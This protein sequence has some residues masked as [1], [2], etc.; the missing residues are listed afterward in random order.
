MNKSTETLETKVNPANEVETSVFPKGFQPMSSITQK[1]EV[2][3]R[4]GYHRRWFRS[5]PG[6]I[7]KAQRAGF[8]FV[9]YDE[10]SLVN[11]DLGGDAKNSGNTDLGTR[12]SIISGDGADA[13]TRVS[14]I[15]G[16][17]ADATGQV[18]RLYLM[19]C[20]MEFYEVSRKLVED[21]NESVAEMLRGGQAGAG[22]AG[23]SYNDVTKRYSRITM[24]DLFTPKN[25]R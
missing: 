10:A 16:D 14:I 8:R 3:E 22:G 25:R 2:P 15:S 23:E 12:V 11:F 5:D 19:E 20:P 1:L 4:P 18:G 17:G 7:A 6:R 9:S 24:P 21:R 13:G